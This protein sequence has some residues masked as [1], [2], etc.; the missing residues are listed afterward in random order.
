M[1]LTLWRILS[2]I[3]QGAAPGRGR[4]L[5]FATAADITSH[6]RLRSTSSRRYERQRTR[7]KFGERS[8]SCAGPRAWNS[9]PSS[10]HE[11]TDTKT[12]KR[13]L[14]AFLFQQAYQ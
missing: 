9:L 2:L 8:F 3:H 13:Q 12:F 11:L 7:L 14:N 5:I 10:L 4:S 1:D 6:P